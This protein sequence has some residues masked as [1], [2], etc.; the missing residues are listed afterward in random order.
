MLS[1]GKRL[2]EQTGVNELGKAI[3]SIAV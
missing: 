2:E 1:I 3:S